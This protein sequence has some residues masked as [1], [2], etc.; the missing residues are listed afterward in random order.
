MTFTA[1]EVAGVADLFGGLPPA[2]LERALEE[3]AFR[4]DEDPLDAG[5]LVE[6]AVERY[7][8]V[9]L[10]DGRLAP[11]PASFPELPDRADDLPHLLDADRTS[12]D[13]AAAAT[14]AADRP[15]AVLAAAV[16]DGDDE[17]VATLREVAYDLEAWGPVD[18]SD[19]QERL[20]G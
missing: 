8:L 13:R 11:G 7:Y 15:R 2:D 3:L 10:A 6:D 18:L 4:R 1:D 19:V 16:D 12:V 5:A 17:R 20:D 14:A 9:E